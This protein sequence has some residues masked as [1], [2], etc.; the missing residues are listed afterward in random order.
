MLLKM[1][2]A[3]QN[4]SWNS[5]SEY[6]RHDGGPRSPPIEYGISVIIE[7]RALRAQI[8]NQQRA[9]FCLLRSQR[10]DAQTDGQTSHFMCIDVLVRDK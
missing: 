5:C 2:Q 1:L 10:A 6:K 8:L 7:S 3:V 4:I 9:W